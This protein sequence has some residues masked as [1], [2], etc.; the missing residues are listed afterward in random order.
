MSSTDDLEVGSQH[1]II[2]DSVA[3]GGFAV[4]RI[5]TRVIFA[6]G[7]I[8]GETVTVK[9][10]RRGRKG[11]FWYGDVV[12]VLTPSPDRVDHPWP[13][14]A[15][16]LSDDVAGNDDEHP[17][18][19]P[20]GGLDLGHVSL[21]R[22]REWKT[23]VIIDQ[24]RRLGRL[25]WQGVEV[26][27]APGDE[28]RGG[29]GSRTRV[30]LAV[31]ASGR[32]GMRPQRSHEVVP[33]TSLPIAA[34]EIDAINIFD[35]TWPRNSKLQ[36]ALPSASQPFIAIDGE[37]AVKK[38]GK[39][40]ARRFVREIVEVEHEGEK[41]SREFQVAGTGF[42]QV[43]RHAPQILVEA[44]LQ[45]AEVKPGERVVDLYSGVGL[46]T[47]FLAHAVGASG[48][49]TAIESDPNAIRAAR[50]NFHDSPNVEIIDGDVRQVARNGEIPTVS[51]AVLDPPRAGAGAQVVR[52]IL[53]KKPRRVVHVS[54]DPATF[55]RDVATYYELGWQMKSLRAFD[56]Y[57]LTHHVET[58]AVFEPL[59]S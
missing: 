51:V 50:R 29:L 34:R 25:D 52:A 35:R 56:I 40:P 10:T 19:Q 49:V 23:E 59:V 33:L 45:A 17:A 24:L 16:P 6:R 39:T 11:R 4:G 8:P 57:P 54:C 31:D 1:E 2:L 18:T 53:A 55:A 37:P 14:A 12:E 46:F 43:H 42:W 58:L 38:R 21:K 9:L 48:K 44:V 13:I 22:G 3:H 7:G 30:Q 36:I 5:E 47:A 28:E 32:A 15:L 41:I 27:A 26:E 20:V